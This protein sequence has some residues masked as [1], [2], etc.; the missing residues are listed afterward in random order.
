MSD[1]M[2]SRDEILGG[3]L[4]RVRRARAC[5]YLIEQEA[6]RQRERRWRVMTVATAAPEFGPIGLEFILGDD[7]TMRGPLPGEADTAYVESFRNARR[8]ASPVDARTLNRTVDSWQVLV[9]SDVPLRAEVLHQ[10]SIRHELPAN[11]CRQI[12]TAFGVGSTEFDAAFESVAD[13]PVA[14]ITGP[15][16]S[17]FGW[18]RRRAR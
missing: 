7:E 10:M 1:A 18:L 17:R 5:L 2:F 16:S 15:S 9:P 14:S 13:R 3:A 4:S 6:S 8:T 11:H 12:L